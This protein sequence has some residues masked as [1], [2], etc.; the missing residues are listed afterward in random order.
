[1][2]CLYLYTCTESFFLVYNV[3]VFSQT[4]SYQD[5]LFYSIP[6]YIYDLNDSM[7]NTNPK[8]F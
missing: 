2:L 3:S 6:I 7:W 4:V 5:D 8:V 1:M